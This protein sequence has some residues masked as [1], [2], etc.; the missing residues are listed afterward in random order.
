MFRCLVYTFLLC[1]SKTAFG[2]PSE[3]PTTCSKESLTRLLPRDSNA[4]VSEATL[5]P[6]NGTFGGGTADLEFP[7]NDTGL[8]ALCAVTIHVPSSNSS[9]YNFGLFLPHSTAWNGRFMASGNGGFGYVGIDSKNL[10]Y[11]HVSVQLPPPL[12]HQYRE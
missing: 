12:F 3:S 2:A 10:I 7:V 6:E 4:T 1:L 9:S 5:V 8:P 11:R